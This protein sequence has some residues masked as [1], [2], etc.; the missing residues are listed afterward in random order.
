VTATT[1]YRDRIASFGDEVID[2]LTAAGYPVRTKSGDGYNV[3]ALTA[4]AAPDLPQHVIVEDVRE[5]VL[6]GMGGWRSMN[7]QR[8][9]RY[10]AALTEAGFATT[11]LREEEHPHAPLYLVVARDDDTA[12]AAL[13]FA[14]ESMKQAESGE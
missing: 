1:E 14:L 12:Q 10:A 6:Y 11:E 3:H 4:E 7:A 13:T 2:A 8:L 5:G 9:A